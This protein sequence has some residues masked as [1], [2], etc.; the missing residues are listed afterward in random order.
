LRISRIRLIPLPIGNIATD[1]HA[2]RKKQFKKNFRSITVITPV[3][4]FLMTALDI[5]DGPRYPF[6]M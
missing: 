2:V 1:W 3:F 6:A 5:L 4:E